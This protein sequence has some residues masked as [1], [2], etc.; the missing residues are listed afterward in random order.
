MWKDCFSHQCGATEAR[1][2]HH[3]VMYYLICHCFFF[4]NYSILEFTCVKTYYCQQFYRSDHLPIF[5]R[6]FVFCLQCHLVLWGGVETP[7]NQVLVLA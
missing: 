2:I 7:T 3:E 6:L 1:T 4:F 5:Q